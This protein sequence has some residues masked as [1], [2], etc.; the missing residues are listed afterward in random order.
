MKKLLEIIK[1]Y[2][3]IVF[4]ALLLLV[5]L[6]YLRYEGTALVLGIIAVVLAAFYL[7][8]GILGIVLGDKLAALLK[9][10]FE[11][12]AVCAFPLFVFTGSLISVIDSN[13]YM[14]P[15]SWTI[16]ILTMIAS[17]A[18]VAGYLLAKFVKGELIRR[19]AHLFA[20]AFVLALLLGILFDF[21]GVPEQ[22]GDISLVYT[23][24]QV[25]YV[26]IMIGSFKTLAQEEPAKVQAEAEPV[27]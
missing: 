15:T 25:L 24:I 13:E 23:L 14:G 16:E 2:L 26:L 21:E 20:L 4:G 3:S 9:K 27:E 5:Y 19:L 22:I 11:I 7:A 18:I 12:V 10:V 1:P 6:N 8:A 17:L